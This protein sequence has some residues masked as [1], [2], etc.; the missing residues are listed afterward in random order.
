VAD[1][2]LTKYNL[3]GIILG[4]NEHEISFIERMESLMAA[5]ATLTQE[6]VDACAWVM[7]C[8][9]CG[10]DPSLVVEELK[11]YQLVIAST[12]R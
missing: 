5:A 12:I 8:S 7:G 10:W 3:S 6:Q 9:A 1:G 11:R 4:M 2:L